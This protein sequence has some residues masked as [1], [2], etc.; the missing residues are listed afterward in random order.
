M[1]K[2]FDPGNKYVSIG[3]HCAALNMYLRTYF[4]VGHK[5]IKTLNM[6]LS[7]DNLTSLLNMSHIEVTE[8]VIFIF[9][10]LN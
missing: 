8:F 6:V 9:K 1:G 3:Q 4:Q 5:M 10:I 2:Y 7:P